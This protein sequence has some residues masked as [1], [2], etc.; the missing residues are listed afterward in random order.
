MVVQSERGE[1]EIM[2]NTVKGAVQTVFQNKWKFYSIKVNEV[3]Y[4][5]GSK[6]DPGV[7]KGDVVEFTAEAVQ[8]GD[9]TYYNVAKGTLKTV[10]AKSSGSGSGSGSGGGGSSGMSK[11]DW[12]LKDQKIQWQAA[13]N[14]AIALANVLSTVGAFPFTD[15]TTP[16]KKQEAVSAFVD[17]Y[18]Q[19]FFQDVTTLGAEEAD[20]SAPPSGDDMAGEE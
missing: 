18:T 10:A 20:P 4:G 13:R 17:Q 7:A 3:F 2:S 11:E 5:T 9:M 6:E 15:K 16:A 12:D 19:Q 1:T 8:K 14:S